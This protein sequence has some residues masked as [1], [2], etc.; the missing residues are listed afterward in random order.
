M[1]KYEPTEE[2]LHAIRSFRKSRSDRGISKQKNF[3]PLMQFPY[4]IY[5]EREAEWGPGWSNKEKYQ[6]EF[7]R[8]NPQYKIATPDGL[9]FKGNK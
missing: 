9:S 1:P 8:S 5:K 7:L 2:D 3:I 6:I 4:A